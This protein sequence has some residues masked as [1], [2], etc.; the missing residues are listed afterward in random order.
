[1]PDRERMDQPT[2]KKSAFADDDDDDG[3]QQAEQFEEHR[4]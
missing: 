3:D 2:G 1:M 4:R